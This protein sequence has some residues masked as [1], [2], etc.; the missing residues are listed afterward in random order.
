VIALG[1]LMKA[2]LDTTR[3]HRKVKVQDRQQAFA[4]I[5]EAV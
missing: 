5:S 3:R 1:W 2:M 4:V